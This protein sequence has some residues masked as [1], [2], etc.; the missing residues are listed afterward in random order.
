MSKKTL[1]VLGI[2]LTILIGTYFYW[3]LCCGGDACCGDAA[4]KEQMVDTDSSNDVSS[5]TANKAAT[6]NPFVFNDSNG[7]FSFSSDDNFN[8]DTSGYTILRPVSAS[9]NE[10]IDELQLYLNANE[11]KS[12]DITGLFKGEEDN[13]SAFPN[14]G[15]ARANA[16]KNYFI[17]KGIPSSRMNLF[18]E[19]DDSLV[20][21]GKVLSG[22]VN[23][24][25][26][27][28]TDASVADE[29]AELEALRE[30]IQA[31]PLVLHFGNAETSINLTAE[32]RQKIADITRY[33]DKTDGGKALVTGHTDNTGSR[34]GN[35]NISQKRAEFA[36]NYLVSNGI[37]EAKIEAEGKGPDE[38]VASNATEDGR[39]MNRR[40]VVTVN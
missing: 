15:M 28:G 8:F 10:G 22:P 26:D 35:V 5:N 32:Q 2:L 14:L 27:T 19:L 29:K 9:V 34:E 11:N 30:R 17:S 21:D 7:E 39:A 38:P 12:V 1:Y 25:I 6:H 4:A 31:N 18:G 13:N 37:T 20:P 3:K 33:L 40:T 23:F 16:V 24:A 36:K